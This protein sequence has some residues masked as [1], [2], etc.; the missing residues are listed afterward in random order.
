MSKDIVWGLTPQ[1]LRIWKASYEAG[2]AAAESGKSKDSNPHPDGSVAHRGWDRGWH[3]K[4]LLFA[5]REVQ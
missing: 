2:I 4:S 1:E 3:I 5:G